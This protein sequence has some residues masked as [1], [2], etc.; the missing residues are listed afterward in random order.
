MTDKDPPKNPEDKGPPQECP[1]EYPPQDQPETPIDPG[2]KP[3]SKRSQK[4]PIADPF[5][6][7]WSGETADASDKDK[8]KHRWLSRK[9][10]RRHS[11]ELETLNE[12]DKRPY[13]Y[14]LKEERN[15]LPRPRFYSR[16]PDASSISLEYVEFILRCIVQQ[17]HQK[18]EQE[19]LERE[20]KESERRQSE[21][22]ID[23]T[24]KPKRLI[25]VDPII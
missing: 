10:K 21:L 24:D 11:V 1:F 25:P 9:P 3:P 17:R 6:R 4:D 7:F 2:E 18:L 8:K 14:V 16:C 23:I 15:L 12:Q 5:S 22:P 20:K 13:K 19:K